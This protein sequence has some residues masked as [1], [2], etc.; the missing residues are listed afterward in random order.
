MFQSASSSSLAAFVAIC[1]AVVVAFVGAVG[2]SARRDSASP[3][4]RIALTT[5]GLTGWLAILSSMVASGWLA[6]DLARRI[7]I[8]MA[9]TIL[10]VV[11]AGVSR[12]GRWLASAPITALVLF[13][14]F[15]LP[16][17]LVLHAWVR[18]GVIPET[19][20]W[21]GANWDIVTGV[22]AILLAPLSRRGGA[23][24]WIFNAIGFA[25]LLNVM[26]VATLSS[27][28]PFA[29]PVEPKL[30]LVLHLP[31]ALIIPICVGGALLGH[32]ALTR[33]LLGTKPAA[34]SAPR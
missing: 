27:P 32:I 33:A 30:A 10:V 8:F 5:F 12:V 23:A 7:P 13:Q 21:T 15:R 11:A 34:D 18:Q 22:F 26:R 2:H 28:L 6:A 17:E 1:A 4:R 29:W 16:L 3:W 24:P 25:M 19:M 31:Y 14:A 9:A 20:T